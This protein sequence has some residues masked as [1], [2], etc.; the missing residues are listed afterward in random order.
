M[1]WIRIS[2]NDNMDM[3]KGIGGIDMRV[4]E[5]IERG[6][7][8]KGFWWICGGILALIILC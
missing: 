7:K 3:D 2:N 8:E 5:E 6:L 1:G 4:Y